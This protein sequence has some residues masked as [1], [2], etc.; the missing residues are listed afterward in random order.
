L[1]DS[2]VVRLCAVVWTR[3]LDPV[4]ENSEFVD[5]VFRVSSRFFFA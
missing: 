3:R 2:G 1:L 4:V 5:F